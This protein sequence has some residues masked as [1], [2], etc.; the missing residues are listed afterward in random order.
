M[1]NRFKHRLID[2]GL[3]QRDVIRILRE[4]YGEKMD[5]STMSQI[6]HGEYSGPKGDRVLKEIEEVLGELEDKQ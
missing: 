5:S 2:L 1:G 4:R 6:I 3:T